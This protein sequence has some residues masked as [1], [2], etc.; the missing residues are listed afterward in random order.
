MLFR[1]KVLEDCLGTLL[2]AV[3]Q[4]LPLTLWLF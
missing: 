2:S 4:K 1:G 3:A